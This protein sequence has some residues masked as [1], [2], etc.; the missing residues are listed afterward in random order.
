MANMNE[1]SLNEMEKVTGGTNR[2]IN[3]GID[4]V[5]AAIREEPRKSSRQ[6]GHLPNGTKVDTI[7]DTLVYDPEAQR[8]FVQIQFNGITGWVASSIL[9]LKR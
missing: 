4:G 5:D 7:S 1:L 8:H 3:T 6:I 2:T 9:G